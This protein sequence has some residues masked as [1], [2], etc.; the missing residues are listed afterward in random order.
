LL[1]GAGECVTIAAR[2]TTGARDI[3]AALY[4]AEGRLLALDSGASARPA[5]QAC[6]DSV[7][8]AYYVLQ[9]YDGDGSFVALPFF[10]PRSAMKGARAAVGGKSALAEIVSA[11]EVA[12]EPASAFTEGLRKRGYDVVGEPRRFKIAQGERVRANLPVEAGQCYTVAAFGGEGIDALHLR[13]LDDNGLPASVAEDLQPHAAAQLCARKTAAFAAESEATAGAGEVVLV[14]YRVDV[15]TAG[16][17]A[18]LW[19]GH[20]LTSV[21]PRTGSEVRPSAKQP[22]AAPQTK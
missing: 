10:G 7:V 9:F 22:E 5:V 12:E 17:D 20:R 19:L 13:L 11:P 2:A 16:G 18:G 15:L 4:T 3:D 21:E 1:I 14:V 6:A 8:R